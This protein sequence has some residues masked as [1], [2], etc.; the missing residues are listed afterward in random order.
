MNKKILSVNFNLDEGNFN[1]TQIPKHLRENHYFLAELMNSTLSSLLN[2][3]EMKNDCNLI[4]MM[5]DV[6]EP[7]NDEK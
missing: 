6:S 4:S 7:K 2:K 5:N 3:E 1:I